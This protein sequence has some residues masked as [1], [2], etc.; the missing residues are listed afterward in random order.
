M[1]FYEDRGD[2]GPPP[3]PFRF[4][5]D[6]GRFRAPSGVVR[7]LGIAAAVLVL[8]ALLS[9]LKSIYVNML[10]FD[11]VDYGSVYRRAIVWRVVL[12]L[13][14]AAV[15]AAVIGGNVW[16][17]RRLAPEAPEE[18]FIEEVDPQAI[19][20]V[21]TVLMV[22]STIFLALI[23]GSAL[24]GSWQT[25]LSWLH[26]VSFGR[27]DPEFG[28]D[29][30][31]YL[32]DLPA[33]HLLQGWLLAL[34][35]VSTLAAGAVY[36]LTFSLQRFV[37]NVTRPVRIHLSILVG[38][39]L[40]LIAAGIWLGIF[41]LVSEAGGL[42]DGA[43]Y[44][45]VHARVPV[46]YLLIVLMAFAGAAVVASAFLSTHY[47]VP[48]VA[49]GGVA[50]AGLLGGGLYPSAVQSVQVRPNELEKEEPYIARNIEFTRLAFDL[51]AVEETNYPARQAL[52]AS[53]VDANQDTIQN[54]RVWDPGPLLDTFNQIQSIRPFYVFG[55][56]DVD[57]YIINGLEQ[58]V[59]LAVRELDIGRV[60]ANWT[61]EQLQLTHGFGA[62]VSPVNEARDE[63]LPVL[64]TRDIPPVGDEVPVSLDGSRIYFGERTTHYVIV[65]TNVAE[66][67]YPLGDGNS[68]TRYGPDRGIRLSSAIRK[69]ALAWEL[70]DPN[71]LISGQLGSDSRLLMHRQLSDRIKKVAPFLT[72]DQDPYAVVLDG[73][74][75]WVQD[76][77]TSSGR[78]PYSQHRGD[79]N[80]MR[81]SVKVVTNALTGDMKFYLV[82]PDEP[83]AAT[84]AKIFP[85]LFTPAEEMPEAL[86][87]HLRYPEDLFRAQSD[88]YLKYHITDPRVFFVGEDV[89]NIPL[90]KT[91]QREEPLQ[92]YYLTMK[93]PG[94][95][96][97][98][99]VIVMPFTPRNKA[100]TVGWLAARS[101]PEH[102]GRL[103]AYRFPTD[104]LVYGPAQ[105]EARIDQ[106]PGISQQLTLWNQS[107]SQVI[108]GN[109]FMLPIA[110]SFLF[111][112]PVY[113][114]AE[115]SRL[116]ELKRV[117]V[118]NGNDIAM[119]P[120]FQEALDVVL[121]RRASTLPGA[122]AGPA[123]PGTPTATATPGATRT[124]TPGGTP[125]ATPTG[126]LTPADLRALIDQARQASN[127]AQQ[128]L[129][130]LRQLLDQIESQSQR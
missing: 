59:M 48:A 42:V 28:R 2:L 19:R 107:G 93:L 18:S 82:E 1:Q 57:R 80:Y 118:A 111:V 71:V 90:Q 54:V 55:D 15:S 104:T 106:T 88:I 98:E 39:A 26:A 123:L 51:D 37:L 9:V 110:D 119:E 64:L 17:A 16:L 120:S 65:R 94:E 81:N 46:R 87:A 113:L 30:S 53:S 84:W 130:R 115:N 89:W 40:L 14:G 60:E 21:G 43:G 20:R 27:T 100:N 99:F 73:Q 25:V 103:R 79:T 74:V 125:G 52:A 36:A 44:A 5:H 61:R 76:A 95:T 96:D 128:D 6:R 47:R 117:V 45:D 68:E 31:F 63:G 8:F 10:W 24:G 121:G 33:Y 101:D 91:G 50:L 32:F 114:Q 86:R 92:P 72:L 23:F 129:D 83:I 122:P 34:V 35:V 112:E 116:P 38:V 105:I 126:T 62:V 22:A 75:Y 58:Q 11:S 102:Y 66:F 127:A 41:D 109:L 49:L 108:R 78:F 70:G 56:V 124:P 67:D 3:D 77:Y 7:W 13:V 97:E 12:F 29:I 4:D 85:Q 69:L